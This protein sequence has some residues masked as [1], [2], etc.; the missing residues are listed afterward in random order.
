MS[1]VTIFRPCGSAESRIYFTDSVAARAKAAA[2][3]AQ[4]AASTEA[5]A[6]WKISLRNVR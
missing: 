3:R 5:T 6:G 2:L 1:I 4:L